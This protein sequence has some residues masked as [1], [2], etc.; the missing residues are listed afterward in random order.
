VTTI[1]PSRRLPAASAEAGFLAWSSAGPFRTSDPASADTEA[2]APPTRP[3]HTGSGTAVLPSP[4]DETEQPT[5]EI[6]EERR[7]PRTRTLV[8]AGVSVLVAAGA[9]TGALL[10]AQPD[11]QPAP[12]PAPSY[13]VVD[14]QLGD[15]LRELQESVVPG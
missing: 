4:V 10:L 12:S 8:A 14:G 11:P 3:L 5:A 15:H 1:D 7:R 2:A 9:A 6:A 13:P